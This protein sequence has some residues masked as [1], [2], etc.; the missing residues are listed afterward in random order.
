MDQ[1]SACIRIDAIQQFVDRLMFHESKAENIDE[2]YEEWIKTYPTEDEIIRFV[3]TTPVKDIEL[4]Q[5]FDGESLL[6]YVFLENKNY[7]KILGNIYDNIDKEKR[8]FLFNTEKGLFHPALFGSRRDAFVI[9][10][11]LYNRDFGILGRVTFPVHEDFEYQNGGVFKGRGFDMSTLIFQKF[12][13]EFQ[14]KSDEWY[15]VVDGKEI[16]PEGIKFCDEQ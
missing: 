14:I 2:L 3:K 10:D 8:E 16:F 15:C 11:K 6:Y 1:R 7:I 12:V 5:Q 13:D 9:I 4:F